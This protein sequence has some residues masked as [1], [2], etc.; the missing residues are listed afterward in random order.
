M[1]IISIKPKLFYKWQKEV[2]KKLTFRNV[3]VAPRQHGKT[4]L[5]SE[6]I[7]S[8][9]YAPNIE[10]PEICLVLPTIGDAYKLYK[11][12]FDK[13]FGHNPAYSWPNEQ[14]K[15]L[16]ILRKDG[17]YANIHIMGCLL[18]TLTLPTTPYV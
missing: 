16:K 13:V 2:W 1:K 3:I 17:S 14:T 18:Y 4:Y 8:F 6:L 10:E 12:E 15:E 7:K 9:C 11:S 5:M